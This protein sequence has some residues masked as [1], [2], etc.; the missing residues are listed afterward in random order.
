VLE[1]FSEK[2]EMGEWNAWKCEKVEGGKFEDIEDVLVI[3]WGKWM[4]KMEQQLIQ[5]L[6]NK[7]K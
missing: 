7:W 1:T 4:W 5:L 3:L 2:K 6:R